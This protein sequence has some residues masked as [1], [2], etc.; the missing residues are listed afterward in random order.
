[1]SE[2]LELFGAQAFDEDVLRVPVRGSGLTRLSVNPLDWNQSTLR[3]LPPRRPSASGAHPLQQSSY[4]G[5]RLVERPA[6]TLWSG[7]PKRL[8]ERHLGLAEIATF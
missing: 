6:K 3:L 2:D 1:M 8:L 5:W 4:V 7:Q